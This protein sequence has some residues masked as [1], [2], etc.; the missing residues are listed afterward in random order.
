MR[1]GGRRVLRVPR[2][3]EEEVS[4]GVRDVVLVPVGPT[5]PSVGERVILESEAGPIAEGEVAWVERLRL[6]RR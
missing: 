3:S 4:R 5:A 2:G 1:E 6:G